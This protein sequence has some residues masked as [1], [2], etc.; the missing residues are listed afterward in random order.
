M[1]HAPLPVLSCNIAVRLLSLAKTHVAMVAFRP[2]HKQ[3]MAPCCRTPDLQSAFKGF[4]I[5][6][7][8][9]KATLPSWRTSTR[10][11]GTMK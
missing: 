1:P 2:H 4:P 8:T 3:Y 7:R 6:K 5:R 11:S 9:P 10:S